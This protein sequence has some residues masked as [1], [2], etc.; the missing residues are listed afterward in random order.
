MVLD[1]IFASIGVDQYICPYSKKQLT[2][3]R[4]IISNSIGFLILFNLVNV[5]LS[6]SSVWFVQ[7]VC[8]GTLWKP[9][10]YDIDIT[11]LLVR[12]CVKLYNFLIDMNDGSR[13]REALRRGMKNYGLRLFHIS[14]KF[15]WCYVKLFLSY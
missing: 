4:K 11:I 15:T 8:W 10:E 3:A 1:A 5:L 9:I 7:V 12:V 2:N 13:K 6:V 14:S